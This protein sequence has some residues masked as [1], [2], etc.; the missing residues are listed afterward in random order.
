MTSIA[1]LLAVIPLALAT[2]AGAAARNSLGTSV[3]GGMFVSTLVNLLFPVLYER[4]QRLRATAKT[5]P[6][7]PPALRDQRGL[8][9][10]MKPNR[11]NYPSA[12]GFPVHPRTSARASRMLSSMLQYVHPP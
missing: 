4:V 2:G 11:C 1:F 5:E 9:A 8:P 10:A 6:G 7:P 12:V 3:F